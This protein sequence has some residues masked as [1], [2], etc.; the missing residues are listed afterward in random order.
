MEDILLNIAGHV[1][2][3]RHCVGVHGVFSRV[4]FFELDVFKAGGVLSPRD[5]VPHL[6]VQ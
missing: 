4:D 3:V 1:V 5:E 2:S 6:M